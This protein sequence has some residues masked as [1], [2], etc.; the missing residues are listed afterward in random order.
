MRVMLIVPTHEYIFRYPAYLSIADFPAG[1]AY[2]AAALKQAGHEVIGCNPNNDASFTSAAAMVEHYIT[3]ALRET[4]PDL[5]GIGGLCTDYPFLKHCLSICRQT[6]PSVPV[7]MGGGIINYDGEFITRALHPDFALQGDAEHTL[8]QLANQLESG[9]QNWDSIANLWFWRH[10]L[11]CRSKASYNMPE[12]DTLPVPDY[13]PFA[14]EKMHSNSLA[15]RYLYRYTRPEPRLMTLVA[16]RGCP[17]ACTFCVH[18]DGQPYRLRSIDNIFEEIAQQYARHRFNIL[19]VLDELFAANKSRLNEFCQRLIHARAEHGWDFDWL[20]QTHAN[21]RLDEKSLYLAKEAGCYFFSYGMESASPTVLASMRKKIRPEQLSGAIALAQTIPIGFGGNFI[22]GDTAE[23]LDSIDETLN[24]YDTHCRDMHVFL[25]EIRPYPGAKLFNDSLCSGQVRKKTEYY[26]TIEQKRFNLTSIPQSDWLKAIDPI[27]DRGL[28]W[29]IV[30]TDT[31]EIAYEIQTRE[32]ESHETLCPDGDADSDRIQHRIVRLHFD[33]PHCGKNGLY[34]H[35]LDDRPAFHVLTACAHCHRRFR[36]RV[37]L[38][39]L[40][41]WL[42][43]SLS[44]HLSNESAYTLAHSLATDLSERR[45]KMMTMPVSVRMRSVILDTLSAYQLTLDGFLDN[46]PEKKGTQLRTLVIDSPTTALS[47]LPEKAFV[48]VAKG[49]T[50]AVLRS[51]LLDLG[52]EEF[53]DFILV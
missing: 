24:F 34:R 16:A 41:N 3:A 11:L 31:K 10:G 35:L 28:F 30:H 32:G 29:D 25:G 17:F 40:E 49:K 51:Q 52:Y 13:E 53:H 19:V 33:C 46:A 12:L 1:F 47:T 37:T 5:I 22:F 38:K 8:V 6:S 39:T 23:T 18:D 21:A 27:L 45:R 43:N 48:F 14:A 44:P 15:A 50:D 26:D 4:P 9:E 42:F 20:F 7:V 36:L 2:L